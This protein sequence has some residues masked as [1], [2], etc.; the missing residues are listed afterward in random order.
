[1]ELSMTGGLAG[2]V[3]LFLLGMWLMTEGLKLA[4]GPALEGILARSTGTPLR[5][6]FSGV[7]VTALVQSSSA[8]TVAAIGF[9]NAGLLTLGQALWVLFGANVGT[10][11]TG[12]LVALV[13]LNLKIEAFALPLVGA[14]ML[15]HL[16]GEGRRRGAAGMALAGFGVLFIGIDVLKDTFSDLGGRMALPQIASGYAA[17]LLHVLAGVVLTVLMQSSSAAL[18]IALTAAQGGLL[19]LPEAAGVVVGANI[20]T[21]VTALIAV[22][23]ATANARRAASAHVLFNL[24][25]G[26]V[27]LAI[28]PWFLDAIVVARDA[29]DM[30]AAPAATLALFHSAFNVLGV[31]LMWPLAGR[32]TAFL[33]KRFRSAD[34]DAARPR[35][36]DANAAAV[37]ALG[38]DAL[39]REIRRLGGMALAMAARTR[40]VGPGGTAEGADGARLERERQVLRRLGHATGEFVMQLNRGRMTRESARRLAPLL[41]VLRHYETIADLAL[42]QGRIGHLAGQAAPGEFADLLDL[43]AEAAERADPQSGPAPGL[44]DDATLDVLMDRYQALKAA[45]LEDGAAGELPLPAMDALLEHASLT[46]R[47]VEHAVKAARLLLSRGER[48]AAPGEDEAAAS[49]E[50]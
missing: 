23:G 28:L 42:A 48:D 1:M 4:A 19:P 9:V 27:A 26:A 7:L 13:G 11:M 33:E 25:T 6:L 45:L 35:Y 37:P 10:T 18:A 32:L 39:E 46:R 47:V 20:G 22:I 30:D 40:K 49:G 16:L 41:R 3:G 15:L 5:G 12:W 14:G 31:A 44:R 43:A 29:L 50:A 36:L 2:G 17:V 38:I 34:E 21:T 24:L 8:V